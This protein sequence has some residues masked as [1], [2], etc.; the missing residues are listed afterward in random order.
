MFRPAPMADN[1]VRK[2]ATKGNVATIEQ[3]IA[4]LKRKIQHWCT[5]SGAAETLLGNWACRSS[6][7]RVVIH[8]VSPRGVGYFTVTSAI[9]H[10]T[11][12][13]GSVIRALNG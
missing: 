3:R 5:G 4:Q 11:A 12:S 13:S 8:G 10:I 1:P 7:Y 2:R 6:H 9:P